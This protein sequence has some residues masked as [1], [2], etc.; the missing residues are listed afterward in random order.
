MSIS[1]RH[2]GTTVNQGLNH[3]EYAAA[4]TENVWCT[5]WNTS[6]V[7]DILD[8]TDDGRKPNWNENQIRR[9]LS[10]EFIGPLPN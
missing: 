5:K 7:M 2:W 8:M 3:A 4:E 1:P 9:R 10:D 6:Q